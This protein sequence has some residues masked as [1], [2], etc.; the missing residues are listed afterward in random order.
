[1]NQV[2]IHTIKKQRLGRG[3]SAGGGKTAGRGTKGQKSRAGYRIPKRFEGGQTPLMQRLP[4]IH[5]T[6]SRIHKPQT[7]SWKQLQ[8]IFEENTTITKELLWDKKLIERIDRPVKI[9]GATQ[10]T[11]KFNLADD[12]LTSH[13]LKNI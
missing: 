8:D 6:V 1:M 12:L 5:G 4:K 3:I 13:K 2:G 11:A 9:I 10:M 7:V